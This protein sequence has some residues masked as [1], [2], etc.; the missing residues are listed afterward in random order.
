MRG[1]VQN[2]VPNAK[3]FCLL[4]PERQRVTSTAHKLSMLVDSSVTISNLFKSH[5]TLIFYFKAF[6]NMQEMIPADI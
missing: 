3:L 1:G 5:L 2:A 4:P 6:C